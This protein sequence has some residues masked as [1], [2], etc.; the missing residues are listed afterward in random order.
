MVKLFTHTDLDGI[1][2]AV[3]AK[4][5]FS[6]EVDITYCDYTNINNNV[7][8]YLN[9]CEKLADTV[10]ITDSGAEPLTSCPK[11]LMELDA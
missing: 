1:G 10:L 7:L 9:S 4:L 6:D 11:N 8:E 3:L 2:C 5:V